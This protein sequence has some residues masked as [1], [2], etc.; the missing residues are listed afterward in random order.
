M[1]KVLRTLGKRLI[2]HEIFFSMYEKVARILSYR[3]R[4]AFEEAGEEPA[5]LDYQMIE[6]LYG[7]YSPPLEPS[8]EKDALKR[9]AVKRV[10]ALNSLDM[11]MDAVDRALEVGCWDGMVGKELRSEGKEAIGIDVRREGFDDRAKDDVSLIQMDAS[12]MGFKKNSFQLVYSFDAF[13]HFDDPEKVLKNM[14]EITEPGGYI[15]LDFG[16]LYMSSWGLHGYRKI[17]IPYCQILFRREDLLRYSHEKDIPEID[18]DQVNG[19]KL[20]DFRRLWK[21]KTARLEVIHYREVPFIKYTDLIK[22]Y[23]SC[24]KSSFKDFQEFVTSRIEVL[25][26]KTNY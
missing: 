12:Y 22:K 15:H 10:E 2:E 21:R 4:R 1:N 14:V 13:E 3:A 25:F 18:F 26:K 6:E 9:R 5:Y 11:D 16:P 23:P 24:F 19:W 7:R 8:Y 17:P 20:N